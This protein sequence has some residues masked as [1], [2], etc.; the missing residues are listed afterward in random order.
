MKL[1]KM[2]TKKSEMSV[3]RTYP[4]AKRRSD[5]LWSHAFLNPNRSLGKRKL[6]SNCRIVQRTGINIAPCPCSAYPPCAVERQRFPLAT[7]RGRS[8]LHCY[9]IVIASLLEM[10]NGK[11][12]EKQATSSRDWT[13]QV[14]LSTCCLSDGLVLPCAVKLTVLGYLWW[15]LYYS[16]IKV[17]CSKQILICHKP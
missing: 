8:I 9:S 6:R 4:I 7:E 3:R 17:V 10:I 1:H 11:R 2:C 14:G 5:C 16:D 13:T 12:S 15:A